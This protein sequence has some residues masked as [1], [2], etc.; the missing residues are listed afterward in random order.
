MRAR[1]Y[2]VLPVASPDLKTPH[3]SPQPS[4]N[5]CCTGFQWVD[6]ISLTDGHDEHLRIVFD[7]QL[8]V[9]FQPD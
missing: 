7:V 9:Y 6:S 5:T 2:R 8:V 3:T 4:H 1:R